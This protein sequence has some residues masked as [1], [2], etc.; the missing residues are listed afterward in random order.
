MF[1][2]N[3]VAL[4]SC[5]AGTPDCAL[6]PV[7][8]IKAEKNPTAATRRRLAT[9]TDNFKRSMIAEFSPQKNG[10]QRSNDTLSEKLII[11]NNSWQRFSSLS[12]KPGARLCRLRPAAARLEFS[13]R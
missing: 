12:E 3:G 8:N 9:L 10:Q 7:T 1:V 6:T 2:T 11:Q 5:S 4:E 13:A